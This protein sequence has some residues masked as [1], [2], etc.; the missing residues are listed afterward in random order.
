M[1]RVVI[2]CNTVL[3][4]IFATNLKFTEYAD[5]KVTLIITDHTNNASSL[6]KNARASGAFA[7]VFYCET[8][9]L[10]NCTAAIE[11]SGTIGFVLDEFSRGK[12]LNKYLP[13]RIEADVLLAANPD[14]FVF[15]LYDCLKKKNRA[16]KY[17]MYEDGLSAYCVL[18]KTLIKQRHAKRSILHSALDFITDKHYAS[19][20]IESIYLFEPEL[21]QWSDEIPFRKMNKLDTGKTPLIDVL[22]ILFDYK[23][24]KD[25]YHQKYIFFEESYSVE[26][27]RVDD[28]DLVEQIASI[29]GKDNIKIK[30]HPRNPENRFA[31]LGYDTN[32]NTVIPWELILMNENFE[33]KTLLSIASGSIANPFLL[34]GIRTS[35]IVLMNCVKGDFGIDGNIYN[36]FLL[37]KVYLPNP[38]IFKLPKNLDELRELLTE[39]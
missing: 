36:D 6:I 12:I 13:E 10:T 11:R 7:S 39:E 28:V 18:G 21:C 30:I 33:G 32:S 27:T 14:K 35:S 20:E 23:S 4:I 37:N 2:V 16:L 17:Y 19:E 5:D 22:N 9:K 29:V 24:L 8:K 15:L 34:M 1:N 38:D 3:Q 26:K 31:E 25:R